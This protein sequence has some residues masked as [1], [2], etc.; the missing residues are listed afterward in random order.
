[1]VNGLYAFFNFMFVLLV[2][3]SD[4]SCQNQINELKKCE[5]RLIGTAA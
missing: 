1:M 3:A 4:F 2:V 5:I